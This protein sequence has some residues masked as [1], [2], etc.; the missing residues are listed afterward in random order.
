MKRT[1]FF[2]VII[3]AITITYFYPETMINPGE[4]VN[5]HQNLSNDCMVCHQPFGGISNDKCIAC[6]TL[7]EIGKETSMIT[8]PDS[9]NNEKT[10]LFHQNLTN[11]NCIA[12][13]TD[14][15]GIQPTI[16]L[17]KFEHS[18][19]TKS[20]VNNC[21]SCHETPINDLHK[22][23]STDCKSCHNTNEWKFTARFNHDMIITADKSNCVSCHQSPKDSFHDMSG[24]NCNECHSTNKWL[25][26]TFNHTSYFAFDKHHNTNCSTCHVNN[27]FK[28]YTCYGCHEHSEANI[29]GEHLEE[30]IQNFQDCVSCHKSGNEHD[31]KRDNGFNKSKE[32]TT[33]HDKN[34]GEHD[35]DDD[36]DD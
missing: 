2:V 10:V 12:C 35:E 18:L 15:K 7:S 30:G 8:L 23:I 1:I 13:H 14:H 17:S 3:G 34:K 36:H 11:Q 22:Q 25:P 28:T 26:S 19:L 20:V 32:R 5:V 9:I 29:R 4:L 6:H 33:N 21:I 24:T 31:I 27:D 16:A